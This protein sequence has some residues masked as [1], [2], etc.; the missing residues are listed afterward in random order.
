MEVFEKSN[1]RDSISILKERENFRKE[2]D[3]L[4]ISGYS[5]YR[6]KN[7]SIKLLRKE[8][9]ENVFKR[10]KRLANATSG[11]VLRLWGLN[12]LSQG[13]SEQFSD[14]GMRSPAGIGRSGDL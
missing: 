9:L 6:V 4:Y 2:P 1:V 3:K 7:E 13:I 8:G 5:D 12:F 11:Q 10:H 14:C